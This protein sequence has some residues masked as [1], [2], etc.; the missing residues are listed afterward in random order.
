MNNFPSYDLSVTI[1]SGLIKVNFYIEDRGENA[2][3]RYKHFL[4]IN[5][6]YFWKIRC[7]FRSPHVYSIFINEQEYLPKVMGKSL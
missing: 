3:T 7:T 4:L 5:I 2:I 1:A 6:L